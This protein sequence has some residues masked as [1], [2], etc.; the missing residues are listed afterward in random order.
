[1]S[2]EDFNDVYRHSM[3]HILA[4]AVIEI[5][6]KEN[7]QYAIGPQI[8]DGFYYDFLLPRTITSDDFAAIEEK[9]REIIKR[10][11]EWIERE[12][13]KEEGCHFFGGE[14]TARDRQLR[15]ER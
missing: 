1:M 2:R 13:P 8:D 12:V 15:V 4:K 3:S 7:V 6:G 5:F 11:E 9:M 10:R 14:H